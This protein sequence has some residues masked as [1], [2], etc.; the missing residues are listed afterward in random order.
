MAT[1]SE[2]AKAAGV[3][4]STVSYVLS[5]KRPI[6]GETRDRVEDAIRRLGYKPH[7]GARALA[8]SRTQVLA[9]VA[10]LRTDVNVG[11]IMQ[12]VA[13]VVTRARSYEYDVLLLTQDDAQG[14]DRVSSGSMIDGLIVMDIEADDP[15]IPAL[16][17]NRQPSV[18]IGLPNDPQ[19]LSVID[20]D[21][22]AAGRLAL[23]HLL[24]LGHQQVALVGPTPRVLGRHTS[25]ADR[26]LRGYR[27]E[28]KRAGI[29]T[30]VE[31]AEASHAGGQDAVRTVL[32]RLPDV[33]ALVVHNEAAL[34][35]VL[36]GLAASGRTI[37]RDVSVLALC[38]ADVAEA[39][40]VPLTA[41]DLPAAT[42]GEAAVDMAMLR[43]RGEGT[44][45]TRLLTPQVTTRQSTTSP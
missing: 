32:K 25:Y 1:I 34:P 21:F 41:I 10:P 8:S 29:K 45:E 7:A 23:H 16:L 4:S 2:V 11:V 27:Q 31:L 33:S 9:M 14:I 35:G 22:R 24:D 26:L 40:P 37:G 38:P 3:S 6:S 28:A 43:I 20:L 12:F 19:G 13:G 42:I 36:A 18:L 17:A 5:G 44:P 30:V 39:Q 15:R